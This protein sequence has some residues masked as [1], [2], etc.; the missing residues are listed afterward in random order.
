VFDPKNPPIEI[1]TATMRDIQDFVQEL[2]TLIRAKN[3]DE[4]VKRLSPAYFEYISSGEFLGE[5]SQ[6]PRLK[7][8]NIV[9][10]D[11]RDYFLYVVVMSRVGLQANDIE[12]LTMTRVMVFTANQ[13]GEKIR[14][15]TLDKTPGDWEIVD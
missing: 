4:W 1:Y 6:Q 7:S 12:F 9:L 13:R 15:Y 8:Q 2:D 5:V 10:Q 3:Y 11:S 14:I